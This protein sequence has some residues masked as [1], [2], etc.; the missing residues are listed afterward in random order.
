MHEN[1]MDET[2]LRMC[3]GTIFDDDRFGANRQ[4]RGYRKAANEQETTP[5]L[6]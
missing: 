3:D 6:P 4:F 1:K 2:K 5:A